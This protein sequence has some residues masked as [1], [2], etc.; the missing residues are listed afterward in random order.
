MN[1][2][3]IYKRRSLAVVPVKRPRIERVIHAIDKLSDA[4]RQQ[5]PAWLRAYQAI[6]DFY[7]AKMEFEKRQKSRVVKRFLQSLLEVK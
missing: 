2:I 4:L 6:D 5:R 1:A 3:T 7:A